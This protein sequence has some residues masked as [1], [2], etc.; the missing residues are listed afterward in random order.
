MMYR[1]GLKLRN[2]EQPCELILGEGELLSL[3]I[4]GVDKESSE[5]K[6]L[7]VSGKTLTELV[8]DPRFPFPAS[9]RTEPA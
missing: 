1:V 7:W 5:E 6:G 4:K 2:N 9:L 3:P 8:Q